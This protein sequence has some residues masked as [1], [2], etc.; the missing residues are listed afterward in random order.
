MELVSGEFTTNGPVAI[1]P[2]SFHP[3]TF[4]HPGL[5][6]AALARAENVL[7]VLP[8][9]FPHMRYEGVSQAERLGLLKA[10]TADFSPKSRANCAGFCQTR[11]NY[12][13]SAA[14]PPPS[15]VPPPQ[16]KDR[17]EFLSIESNWDNVS[18]APVRDA[19]ENAEPRATPRAHPNS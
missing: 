11:Q 3:P 2:D 13:S 4:A 9:A 17:I 7:F 1:L 10:L 19:I 12:A 5:A 6:E 14:V 18:S 8:R 16:L 15:A